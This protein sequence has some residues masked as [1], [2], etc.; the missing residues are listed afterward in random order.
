MIN[1]PLPFVYA[2]WTD[3]REDDPQITGQSRTISIFERTA[4]LVIM[5]VKYVSHGEAKTA[6]RIVS[7]KPPDAWHLDWIGD[8][9]NEI[10]DY[11]LT[12]LDSNR[13]RLRAIFRVSSKTPGA[14]ARS[15]FLKGVNAGWDKYV[16]A[17]ETD[18]RKQA[19]V[20]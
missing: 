10:G 12:R 17:L 18:Y 9:G 19:T 15:T 5:S 2:W 8:E 11:K 13:T 6:A 20:G 3:F 14:Y 7:L 16:P 1:A 4:N